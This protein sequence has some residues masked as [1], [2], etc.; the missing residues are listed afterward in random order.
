PQRSMTRSGSVTGS[1]RIRTACAML[2]MAVTAPIATARISTTVVDNQP[3]RRT[4]RNADLT[5]A[6]SVIERHQLWHELLECR[7]RKHPNVRPVA[8]RPDRFVGP[9]VGV[10]LGAVPRHRRQ[11]FLESGQR[12]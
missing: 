1:G 8:A 2:K 3:P 10:E 7:S 9:D 12:L 11:F 5:S 4:F 6:R